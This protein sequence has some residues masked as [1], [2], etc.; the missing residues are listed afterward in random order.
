MEA[1][2]NYI[3]DVYPLNDDV[4]AFI[5]R[6]CRERELK[7]GETLYREGDYVNHIFYVVDGALRS[8]CTHKNGK[9][10][11]LQFAIKNWWISDYIALHSDQ[12]AK[13]TVEAIKDSKIVEVPYD[14]FEEFLI[15]FPDFEPVQRRR[16]QQHLISYQKRLLD[17]LQLT[18]AERYEQFLAEFSDIEKY[19]PNYQIASYLGITQESLSRIRLK[20]IQK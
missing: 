9:E 3:R 7:K 16:L 2:F 6:T 1:L 20:R 15:E 11:T 14:K 12:K 4:K 13:L 19:V 10:H 8:Y 5:I 17:Q 18:A